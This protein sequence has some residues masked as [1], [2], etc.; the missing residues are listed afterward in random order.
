[1][2]LVAFFIAVHTSIVLLCC[3]SVMLHNVWHLGGMTPLPPPPNPPLPNSK[4]NPVRV[5]AN[6]T[7]WENFAIFD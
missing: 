2:P 5:G 7:G 4:E 3:F 6:H 1:M